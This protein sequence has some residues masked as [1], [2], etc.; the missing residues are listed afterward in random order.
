MEETLDFKELIP[1]VSIKVDVGSFPYSKVLNFLGS[2]STIKGVTI[3]IFIFLL[4]L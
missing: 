3:S 4:S 2:V 1:T